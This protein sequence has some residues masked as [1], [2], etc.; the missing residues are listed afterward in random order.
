MRTKVLLDRQF[1]PSC[2]RQKKVYNNTSFAFSVCSTK[3]Q[4]LNDST[5]F[6]IELFWSPKEGIIES[7]T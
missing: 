1:P 7:K 6:S 2:I 4:R 5:P 3:E